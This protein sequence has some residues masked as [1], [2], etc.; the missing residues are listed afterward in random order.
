MTTK[1]LLI[2]DQPSAEAYGVTLERAARG[3]KVDVIEEREPRAIV[4]LIGKTQPNGLLLDLELTKYKGKSEQFFPL[5]GPGLA[6]EFRTKSNAE[7]SL[8]IP[9]VSLSF[10][11]RRDALIGDD[12]TPNDLFDDNISKGDVS[13]GAK[14]FADRLIDLSAGYQELRKSWRYAPSGN[15]LAKFLGIAAQD[16]ERIDGRLRRDLETLARRPIHNVAGFFLRQLL[17]FSGPL[18]DEPTLAVRL[19]VDRAKSKKAW[20]DLRAKFPKGTR[21]EGIFSSTHERWWMWQIIDWWQSLDGTPGALTMINAGDRVSYLK[22]RFKIDGLPSIAG[23]T[24]SPGSRFWHVCV[25]SGLPVDPPEGY[26]ISDHERMRPWHDKRFLCRNA[27]LRSVQDFVFEPG[28][29]ER[30]KAFGRR[31]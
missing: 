3:L 4:N 19:G 8:L 1:Y 17:Q 2:D 9:I 15:T 29:K 23:T 30:L 7:S 26:I 24:Q 14:Q 11:Q 21:Y 6:Q 22:K 13:E 20:E 18:I 12:S 10:D 31:R 16:L 27:A 25:K 28:E 5:D